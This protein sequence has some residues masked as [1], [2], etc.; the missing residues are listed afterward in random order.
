MIICEHLQARL[1]PEACSSNMRL[2]VEACRLITAS[3]STALV[4]DVA[5]DRLM[6][7]GVC[8]RCQVAVKALLDVD[9][10]TVRGK[11]VEHIYEEWQR[12]ERMAVDG[13]DDDYTQRRKRQERRRKWL[14]VGDNREKRREYQRSWDAARR[15]ALH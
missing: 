6:R 13:A 10:E 3:G 14:D 5:V 8:C 12:V 15:E 1:S 7:C 11:V 2:A 4:R 9:V